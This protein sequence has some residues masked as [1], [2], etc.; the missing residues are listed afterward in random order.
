MD[1]LTRSTSGTI[2]SG[3]SGNG[4]SSRMEVNQLINNNNN[5]QVKSS[6]KEEDQTAHKIMDRESSSYSGNRGQQYQNNRTQR[7]FDRF[8]LHCTF[9]FSKFF[10]CYL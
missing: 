4:A 1:I 8:V 5:G 10:F 2:P 3:G 6:Y 7:R 9:S